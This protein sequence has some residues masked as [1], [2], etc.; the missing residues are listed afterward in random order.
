[1]KDF[2]VH[3]KLGTG[4]TRS[5]FESTAN[6]IHSPDPADSLFYELRL[7]NNE[8]LALLCVHTL[9]FGSRP[10]VVE[11]LSQLHCGA[12][13]LVA[14]CPYSLFDV[15]FGDG[16]YWERSVASAL[17]VGYVDDATRHCSYDRFTETILF[18]VWSAVRIDPRFARFAFGMTKRTS[19]LFHGV[20]IGRVP[21]LAQVVGRSLAPRWPDNDCFWP[22]LIRFAAANSPAQLQAARLLGCQ[23]LAGDVRP[24][25]SGAFARSPVTIAT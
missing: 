22:D 24:Q 4:P 10:D 18:F 5:D 14:D 8:Y 17:T 9:R 2:Y 3:G 23:L 6:S 16:D 11:K 15:C 25:V 21:M 19:T 12:L 1:M 7:L 20:P 13:Q